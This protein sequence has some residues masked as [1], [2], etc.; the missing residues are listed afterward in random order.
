MRFLLMILFLVVGASAQASTVTHTFEGSGVCIGYGN[1]ADFSYIPYDC[2]ARMVVE[3]D[4]SQFG[5]AVYL[6]RGSWFFDLPEHEGGK[7]PWSGYLGGVYSFDSDRK[8]HGL[9]YDCF[10]LCA[11]AK[12][13]D[14]GYL[15]ELKIFDVYLTGYY[16]FGVGL[17]NFN[18]SHDS[19]YGGDVFSSFSG[20]WTAIQSNFS[21]VEEPSPVSLPP[22]LLLLF[23]GMTGIITLSRRNTVLKRN[24]AT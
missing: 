11:V 8:S 21:E 1:D 10:E 14:N 24:S 20:E 9:P 4:S 23:A 15:T 12:T 7:K 22:T 3:L 5:R 13:N 16:I 17:E 2:T 6:E 19:Y 18:Y